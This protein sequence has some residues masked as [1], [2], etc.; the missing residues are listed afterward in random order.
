ME[1]PNDIERARSGLVISGYVHPQN[2]SPSK[3][4]GYHSYNESVEFKGHDVEI[5]FEDLYKKESHIAYATFTGQ[6]PSKE[7]QRHSFC[8]SCHQKAMYE[9]RCDIGEMLCQNGHYWY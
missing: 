4:G 1:N 2:P 8:P 7:V 6:D 3:E 5:P 9:C